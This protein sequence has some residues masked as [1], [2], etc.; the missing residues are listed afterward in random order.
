MDNQDID[1]SLS[2]QL[3][4]ERLKRTLTATTDIEQLR[5]A[6]LYLLNI[7]FQQKAALRWLATQKSQET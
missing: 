1:L 2:E 3:H 4:K 6:A 5:Q 7:G